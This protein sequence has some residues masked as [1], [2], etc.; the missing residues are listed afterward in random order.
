[1]KTQK[2]LDKVIHINHVLCTILSDLRAS[3]SIFSEKSSKMI[4]RNPSITKIGALRSC[5]TE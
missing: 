2:I 5:D 4:W 1:M 3:G